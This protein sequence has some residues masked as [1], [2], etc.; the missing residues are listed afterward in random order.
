MSIG[1]IQAMKRVALP[2]EAEHTRV[3][4][5][6]PDESAVIG[7]P[8][9]PRL[10]RIMGFVPVADP[11]R[12][13]AFFIDALGLDFVSGDGFAVVVRSGGRDIRLVHVPGHTPAAFTVLGWDVEDIRAEVEEL[14]RRGVVFVRVP[15]LP[16]D[17][18]GVW[19]PP[20]GGH[21]AWF[22]DPDGNTLSLSQH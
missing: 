1:R 9:H 20:G 14:T 6:A 17:E 18:Q 19:S 4:I 11:E 21:V 2:D 13:R 5:F 12:A 8:A 3:E 16:Q 22:K 7:S 15:G 10:G